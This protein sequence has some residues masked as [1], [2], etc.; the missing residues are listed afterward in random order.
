MNPTLEVSHLTKSYDGVRAV[1]DLDLNLRPGSFTALIGP[2]GCGKSTT[3]QM[4]AGLV[5][6]DQGRISIEG[7]DVALVPPERRPVSMVFQ[8]PLLFPHLTVAQNVAF[9]LRMQKVSRSAAS[10]RVAD[11]L[12]RVQLEGFGDR[13][14]HELSGG[15]E[16]RV[17]LA[18]ALV[19]EPALILLDEPFSQLDVPLRAEMRALVRDLHDSSGVTTLFVTHDQGESVE[20]ADQIMVMLGGRAE[21]LG[22]P[23]ELYAA[24]PTLEAARFLG[25]A[26][27]LR[28]EAS[29]TTFSLAGVDVDVGRSAVTGPAILVVR[30]ETLVLTPAT[31]PRAVGVVIDSVQFAGTHLVVSAHTDDLQEVA[32]HVPVGTPVVVG[33]RAGVTF[34]ADR[35]TVFAEART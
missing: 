9:G 26:N 13:R 33:E 10:L 18:R 16:Q 22:S 5:R 7:V 14:P 21:A 35:C 15:Q 1:D 4:I 17:A 28:G 29:S 32:L 30:P 6:P 12:E 24:P 3:L 25:V 8:K 2:S 20:I 19:L 23:E 11:M 31:A 27:E 34:A